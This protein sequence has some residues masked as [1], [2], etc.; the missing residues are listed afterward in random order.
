MTYCGLLLQSV[1]LCGRFLSC[2]FYFFF[3]VLFSALLSI[4]FSSVEPEGG[5]RFIWVF[6]IFSLTPPHP[7]HCSHVEFFVCV[8]FVTWARDFFPCG[9]SSLG[10]RNKRY[11]G[12]RPP[13]ELSVDPGLLVTL[14][15]AETMVKDFLNKLKKKLLMLY[16][17]DFG[18]LFVIILQNKALKWS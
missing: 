11:R 9:H 3:F 17:Y 18:V 7:R 16:F 5:V 14:E 13:R 8:L 12:S 2:S 10:A 15:N 6:S 1:V 4:F